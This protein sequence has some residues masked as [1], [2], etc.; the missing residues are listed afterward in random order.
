MILGKK[1]IQ[2][3]IFLILANTVS[4]ISWLVPQEHHTRWFDHIHPSP[5]SSQIH[6]L[7]PTHPTLYPLFFLITPI[8]FDFCCPYVLRWPWG[9]LMKSD[10]RFPADFQWPVAFLTSCPP[11]LPMLEFPWLELAQVLLLWSQTLALHTYSCPVVSGRH[12]SLFSYVFG[13]EE[14]NLVAWL[15]ITLRWQQVF[16]LLLLYD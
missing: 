11:P 14:L 15:W 2:W 5:N 12:C 3:I 8:I 4:Y 13:G 10:A 9:L 16:L 1:H 7:F 6:P